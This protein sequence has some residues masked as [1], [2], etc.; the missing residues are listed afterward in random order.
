M[1]LVRDQ[2]EAGTS[3][4]PRPGRGNHIGERPEVG[5][6]PTLEKCLDRQRPGV[7][8][9][10]APQRLLDRRVPRSPRATNVRRTFD[11]L[12]RI[13]TEALL[14]GELPGA[15][16]RAVGIEKHPV[17]IEGDDDTVETSIGAGHLTSEPRPDA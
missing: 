8:N 10:S 5:V 11:E 6:E 7:L 1:L 14:H 2:R 13:D 12:G 15:R 4:A 9:K 3:V 16:A 17:N